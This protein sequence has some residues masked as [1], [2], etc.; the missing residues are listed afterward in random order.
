M[1]CT[2]NTGVAKASSNWNTGV[3]TTSPAG[4][5]TATRYVPKS[6][7]PASRKLNVSPLVVRTVSGTD[8][9]ASLVHVNTSGAV[10]VA[11]TRKAAARLESPA[12]A[13]LRSP[14]T[15]STV[16]GSNTWTKARRDTESPMSNPPNLVCT[17]QS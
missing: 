9:D 5:L 4:P 1:G 12:V 8:S 17:T 13:T 15:A 6:E 11:T 7:V 14:G 10:P 3:V 16:T 2:M